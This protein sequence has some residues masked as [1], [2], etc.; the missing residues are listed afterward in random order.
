M[1]VRVPRPDAVAVWLAISAQSKARKSQRIVR[2]GL[3][4]GLNFCAARPLV[5]VSF[6]DMQKGDLA[7]FTGSLLR[8]LEQAGVCG[9]SMPATALQQTQVTDHMAQRPER[10][11]QQRGDVQSRASLTA[12]QVRLLVSAL[13]AIEARFHELAHELADAC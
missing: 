1:K 7:V 8:R 10:G 6:A 2:A 13:A 9:L 11:R 12:A 3:L 5:V 4:R